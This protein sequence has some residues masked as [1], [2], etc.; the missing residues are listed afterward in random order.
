MPDTTLAE[1]CDQMMGS[2][3]SGNLDPLIAH[4]SLMTVLVGRPVY[5]TPELAPRVWQAP[6]WWVE[7]E[8]QMHRA[9][10]VFGSVKLPDPPAVFEPTSDNEVLLLHVPRPAA[11][12]W[13]LISEH[14]C[15]K[16]IFAAPIIENKGKFH[17]RT[18][19]EPN[20]QPVWVGFDPLYGKGLAAADIAPDLTPAGFTVLS[21]VIQFPDWPTVW[22]E[23]NYAP[24]LPGFRI[25]E[26]DTP[27]D[28]DGVPFLR[29]TDDDLPI[30]LTMCCTP[31]HMG[32]R[33]LTNP[34]VRELT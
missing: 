3:Q 23:E 12:L 6:I 18:T 22:R 30:Y 28:C 11:T 26:Q 29:M 24:S 20:G 4:Y 25:G 10:Q 27:S 33:H 31:D 7:P 2:V 17:P 9:R 13:E 21:A 14:P 16:T 5:R 19:L 1:L 34:I 32:S 15:Y 8:Q